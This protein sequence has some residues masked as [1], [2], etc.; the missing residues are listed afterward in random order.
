MEESKMQCGFLSFANLA[1]S[2]H[3]LFLHLSTVGSGID[4]LMIKP[5]EVPIQNLSPQRAAV[6]AAY[7][8]AAFWPV[9][10]I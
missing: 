1:P 3:F 10:H 6:P 2:S 4:N 7:P 8:A 5:Q 9:P